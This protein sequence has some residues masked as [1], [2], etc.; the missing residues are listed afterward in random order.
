VVF[1]QEFSD[2]SPA[3]R[4]A[5]PCRPASPASAIT[6]CCRRLSSGCIAIHRH[7]QD[8]HDK[9]LESANHVLLLFLSLYTVF[10]SSGGARTYPLVNR[11]PLS[12]K[13]FTRDP[14]ATLDLLLGAINVSPSRYHA[15]DAL[16]NSWL[17]SMA[18]L[19]TSAKGRPFGFQYRFKMTQSRVQQNGY[20]SALVAGGP[21]KQ[22]N[23]RRFRG[24][25]S[26]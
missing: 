24:S 22:K 18:E 3:P 6:A 16:S 21:Y 2:R 10:G 8:G 25:I 23:C 5:L 26:L 1:E 20:S 4:A 14:I 7:R 9:G 15:G 11:Q 13:S 12:E 19:R 17:D